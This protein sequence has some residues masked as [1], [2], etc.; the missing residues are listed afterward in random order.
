MA[1]NLESMFYVRE[2]PWHGL[3]IRV[4]EALN[5]KDALVAAGLDWKVTQRPIYTA[6]FICHT[7]AVYTSE[8]QII[9]NY[10]ANIR[11]IDGAVL[12]VVTDRYKIVQNEE[13]FAFTD[14]LIGEGVRYETAGSLQGGRRVWILG[15]LP[16]NYIIAGERIEPYM[17]FSNSHD[18]SAAIKV[19]MTPIRVV[20]QNTLNLAM[21]EAK[22][23][24][25]TKHTGGVHNRMGLVD[26]AGNGVGGGSN[27]YSG[28]NSSDGVGSSAHT[29]GVLEAQKTLGLAHKYME[30]L[31]R[32]FDNLSRVRLS[33]NKVM[34]F[35]NEL[36]P[37]TPD[38]SDI[39]RKNT[40]Q[41]RDDVKIRYFEAPDLKQ[42][43]K[44]GYRFINAIS[45]H[46]THV[47]PLR[48]TSTYRENLFLKTLEGHPMI[49]KAYQM[50]KAA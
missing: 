19:A 47:K 15:K 42:L 31:G 23:S 18:G 40:E 27:G 45:D 2:T 3:G 48:E 6:D 1:A 30:S 35:I 29:K 37:L 4:E 12:G 32:E 21:K 49:D 36:I 50:I 28:S 11:D 34:E 14:A 16:D 22:R 46:A 26:V 43:G 13:A 20:C 8:E 17:V 33:D 38:A 9:P 7:G 24:W 44:N 41:L 5:S 39:Q 25:S 10:K